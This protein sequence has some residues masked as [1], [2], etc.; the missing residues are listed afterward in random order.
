MY[1]SAIGC[2]ISDVTLLIQ[3]LIKFK[4]ENDLKIYAEKGF[5]INIKTFM[6]HGIRYEYRYR[7]FV[8]SGE[9]L[10]EET[11]TRKTYKS[12]NRFLH[13]LKIYR[14]ELQRKFTECIKAGV[15]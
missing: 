15:K 6:N 3:K 1:K 4:N 7:N 12:I 8:V 14:N 11:P 5:T 9:Y 10:G 2:E 13:D